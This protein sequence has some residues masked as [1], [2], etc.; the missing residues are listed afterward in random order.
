MRVTSDHVSRILEKR[1]N[2]SADLQRAHT[3]EIYQNIPRVRQIDEEI[4]RLMMEVI[5]QA[6]EGKDTADLETQR[7]GLRSEKL[8]LLEEAGYP[9]DYLDL[10]PTCN[11]CKDTGVYEDRMCSCKRQLLISE[12]YAM[13]SIEDQL[14]RENFDRFDMRLFRRNPNPGEDLSPWEN[15]DYVLRA[16]KGYVKDFRKTGNENLLYYGP[17][18][19]GKT[20]L[21]NAIA[22]GV[23]DRGFAVLYQSAPDLFELLSTYQFLPAAEKLQQK[24]L[25][26]RIYAVDLLV[27]DDLGSETVTSVIQA[28][29]SELINARLLSRR[30]TIMSTNL[31]PIELEKTY[32]ARAASRI[33]GNYR[34]FHI[35]GDDLRIKKLGL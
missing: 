9:S 4:Q 23:I 28:L 18:G 6:M 17:V 32:G 19:T 22:K 13:S 20:F 7:R 14:E 26:D 24:E 2:Q 1:R 31:E 10:K 27:I 16:A 33:I 25:V 12:A 8:L 21:V 11:Y 34:L 15:M 35:Y 30:A 3:Q 5:S 29:L